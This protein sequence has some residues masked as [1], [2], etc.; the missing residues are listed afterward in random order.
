M[1]KEFPDIPGVMKNRL[2]TL[3]IEYS[4]TIKRALSGAEGKIKMTW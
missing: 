3:E 1:Q 2:K 4:A